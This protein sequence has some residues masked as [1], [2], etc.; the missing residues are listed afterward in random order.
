VSSLSELTPAQATQRWDEV[1]VHAP[2]L[3][4]LRQA[5]P[6]LGLAGRTR[7]LV[8]RVAAT[9]RPELLRVPAA[10][11]RRVPTTAELSRAEIGLHIGVEL[12]KHTEVAMIAR[13]VLDAGLPA[14]SR[15]AGLRV[16]LTGPEAL[17]WAVG[18]PTVG[19][20]LGPVDPAL[21]AAHDVL[22][23]SNTLHVDP[24]VPRVSGGVPPV[25]TVLCAPRG[26]SAAGPEVALLDR[27]GTLRWAD[28]ERRIESWTG[29]T[30]NDIAAL[31]A[32]RAVRVADGLDPRVVAQLCC[33]GIPV[34]AKDPGLDAALGLE[35]TARLRTLDPDALADPIDR[36]SWS[37]DTRRLALA[38]FAPAARWAATAAALGVPT[39]PKPTVSVLVATRRTAL[40][41]F[42]LAQIARQ[43]WA[44]LQVVLVLHGPTAADPVVADATV[45]FPRPLQIVEVGADVV[46]GRA[47]NIGLDHCAGDLVTKFDDDDWYGPAHVTDLVQAHEHSGA[48]LVG[49]GG[50][51][52]YLAGPD[53][54]IRWTHVPTEAATTWVHGGTILLERAALRA[55]GGFAAVPVGEDAALLTAVRT[56]GG[57][58]Y[59]IHDLGFCYFR[60]RD[61]TWIPAEGDTRWMDTDAVKLPG[62]A[63][64]PQLD[65]MPHPW[66]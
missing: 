8:V 34:C 3:A 30:E 26:F 36:E 25:D 28:A 52:V 23:G 9:D 65:P 21:P 11:G 57:A 32:V 20:A 61:H 54:T 1:E 31:R 59:G 19:A 63:P 66:R 17:V 27:D 35:L 24:R 42:A 58:I 18:D 50:Y 7:R 49:C 39:R 6:W 13:A 5:L 29:L 48:L 14:F 47:L 60:G 53:V 37:I 38:R 22:V 51:Y 40:L 15:T 16:G 2:S 55:L 45:G 43:D 64:P 44:D 12:A 33:A 10:V 56:A 46:F 4:A 41:P 62:F